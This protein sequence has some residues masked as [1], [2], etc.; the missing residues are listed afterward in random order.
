MPSNDFSDVLKEKENGFI[1]KT[2]RDYTVEPK[3]FPGNNFKSFFLRVYLDINPALEH[4]EIY[5]M[6]DVD[7]VRY[8]LHRSYK[9]P[10]RISN[11]FTTNF[12]IK[13]WAYG[14]YAIQAAVYP[15]IGPILTVNGFVRFSVTAEDNVLSGTDLNTTKPL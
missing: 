1:I 2:E 13:I 4:F 5:T 12:E 3:V 6:A 9:D 8:Q 10:V 15:K 11:D 7:L 14:Y